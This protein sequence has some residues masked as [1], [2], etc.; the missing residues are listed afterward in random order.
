MS[1]STSAPRATATA[2]VA[3]ATHSDQLPVR[4]LVA[5]SLAAF[6]LITGAILFILVYGTRWYKQRQEDEESVQ[7]MKK[8]VSEADLRAAEINF[9]KTLPPLPT[10]S[11]I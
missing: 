2:A 8:E 11:R 9:Q 1:M 3:A 10:A 5:I 6:I 4:A 7:G